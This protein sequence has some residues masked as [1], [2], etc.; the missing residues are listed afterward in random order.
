MNTN[1]LQDLIRQ[2]VKL[3]AKNIK[4]WEPCVHKG[5]DHGKKG[6]RAAF[7]FE[8]NS[9]T[10]HCF[11]CSIVTGYDP[12]KNST[13][14]KKMQQVL[15]DFGIQDDE[16]QHIIFANYN[17]QKSS[18]PNK[19]Q[20]QIILEPTPITFPDTFYY[21]KDAVDGDKWA[22]IARD[23]LI[24]D[25]KI[26]PDEYPFL[27][28]KKTTDA[29]L[30]KW[31]GRLIIPIFKNNHLVFYQGRDLTNKQLKKY[32][33]PPISKNNVLYG[34]EK[35]FETTDSP[36]YIVEGWFDA[37]S[38]DGIAILGNELSIEQISWINKSSRPKVYIPDRTGD[39]YNVATKALEQGWYISTP[40][41]GRE[42]KDMND[43]V[44][45][46]GKLYVLKTL[47]D[48]VSSG[49]EAL[50]KLGIYCE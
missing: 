44:K 12:E 26:Q 40:D 50:I 3:G 45:R 22:I 4:G 49:Y 46:Y 25:R 15:Q 33:S 2:N 38:I 1:T 13:M 35:L 32:E 14:P 11:N 8:G 31:F 41:I 23:Y 6:P 5:C 16:W 47:S 30:K 21:L 36:L 42:C 37:F 7:L 34:Y 48:N 24:H 18:S 10:F 39:G 28:S 17:K 9:V 43:A 27:L 29:K 20:K 19:Q